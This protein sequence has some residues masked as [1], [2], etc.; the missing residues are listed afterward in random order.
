MANAYNYSNVAVP[1]T[2]A[3]NISAGATTVSVV[4]TVGFPTVPYVIAIDY[5]ASTEELMKVTSVAGL[6]LT[7]TRGFGGTSAQSHSLGAAVR[8]VYNA[9]DATDFRTHEDSTAAH[10]ATGAVVGTTNTQTL[11]N[12]TLTSPTVNS[13]TVTTPSIT[14]PTITGGGSLAGTF[15]GTPTF[16]GNV[17]FSAAASVSGLLTASG[18]ASVSRTAGT[19]PL[20]VTGAASQSANLVEIKDSSA[21]DLFLVQPDG[22]LDIKRGAHIEGGNTLASS[23]VIIKEGSYG[24]GTALDVRN[25]SDVSLLT[26]GDSGL[27]WTDPAWTTYTPTWT[28]ATTNPV[29]GNGTIA[30][31]YRKFGRTVHLQIDL[32]MGSTTTYGTGA[33]SLS[34]PMAAGSST[35]SRIGVA[36][37]LGAS[38]FPGQVVIS[39]GATATSP[40]FPAT[41]SVSNLSSATSTVPI[42]WTTGNELRVTVT[43]EAAS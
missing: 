34:L 18:G 43:Y 27:N 14:N 16:S 3:G 1:T 42:T 28:A 8:P 33:W 22:F 13:P 30:G 4:S 7:G 37:A 32:T 2:L 41:S 17:T 40:F 15:S 5:G 25:D 11:T 6:A 24:G 39:A 26:V 19:V 12:K 20:T 31:R 29:L 38:R 9:V 10:G 21:N 35:G 36:Q 23:G